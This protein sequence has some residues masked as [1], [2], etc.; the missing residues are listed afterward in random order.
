MSLEIDYCFKKYDL[1]P[2]FFV[3]YNRNSYYD[4]DNKDLR[5]TFDKKLISRTDNLRLDYGNSGDEY[6][7]N[8]TYI[9]EIKSLGALP[10]WFT[11]ILSELKIYPT[12]FS[13]IGKIYM[14]NK[15]EE[16]YV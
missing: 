2:K 6:F 15:K 11:N 3:S 8:N 7:K 12:S 16:V 4:K 10:L 9:M 13:K 5:I 14:K 1:K